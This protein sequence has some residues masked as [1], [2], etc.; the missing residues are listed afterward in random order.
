MMLSSRFVSW[1]GAIDETISKLM[2]DTLHAESDSFLEDQDDEK[3]EEEEDAYEWQDA[4]ACTDTVVPSSRKK[5]EEGL[6]LN[7]K[8]LALVEARKQ[9]CH[10]YL[11]RLNA[12]K[13]RTIR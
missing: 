6:L 9:K 3:D 11:K 2:I 7:T 10:A 13:I 5:K 12:N 8:L 4:I 1:Q